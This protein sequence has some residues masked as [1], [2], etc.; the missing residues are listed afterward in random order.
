[1]AA[2]PGEEHERGGRDQRETDDGPVPVLP[3]VLGQQPTS[4]STRATAS[5]NRLSTVGPSAHAAHD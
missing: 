4:G 2:Q 3:D 1:V 5:R